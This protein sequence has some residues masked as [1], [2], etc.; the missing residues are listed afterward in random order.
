MILIQSKQKDVFTYVYSHPQVFDNLVKH[1]YQKSLSDVLQKLLA[2]TP[3]NYSADDGLSSPKSEKSS[4][5][6]NGA[7][8]LTAD[9]I[10]LSFIYKILER[11]T[12]DKET[13]I[14]VSLNGL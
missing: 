6:K 2:N 4:E 9:G 13:D 12:F 14:E 1:I 11:L 10:R 7:E 8:T 3:T 5:N